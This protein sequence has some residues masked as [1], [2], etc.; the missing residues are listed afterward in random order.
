MKFIFGIIFG[1]LVVIFIF[2]NTEVVQISF[3]FWTLS[4][5]R[6]IM[7]FIVFI[8]GI[9]LGAGLKSV[10]WKKKSTKEKIKG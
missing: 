8:V 3:L 10:D 2:Q 1:V 5:S 4:A 9:I 7:Y 6:S